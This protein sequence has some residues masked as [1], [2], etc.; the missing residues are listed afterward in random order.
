M[1]IEDVDQ[2]PA[3]QIEKVGDAQAFSSSTEE[4]KQDEIQQQIAKI[5]DAKAKQ[6]TEY[7]KSVKTTFGLSKSDV[8]EDSSM[9]AKISEVNRKH[10]NLTWLSCNYLSEKYSNFT[11]FLGQLQAAG[12]ASHTNSRDKTRRNKQSQAK[13]NKF[14]TQLE[15]EVKTVSKVTINILVQNDELHEVLFKAFFIFTLLLN[16]LLFLV[17]R[18]IKYI[19]F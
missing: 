17:W 9:S 18:T 8:K 7:I 4:V 19:W 5:R 15:K 14:W 1:P 13:S 12:A 6:W 3:E 10:G 11:K 2:V 16:L